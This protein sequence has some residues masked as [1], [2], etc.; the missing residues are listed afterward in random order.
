MAVAFHVEGA[1]GIFGA[2]SPLYFLSEGASLNPYADAVYEL[3]T[4]ASGLSMDEGAVSPSTSTPVGEYLETVR[5]EEP[6]LPVRAPGRA[7]PG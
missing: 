7:G 2:G 1:S 4:D 6:L 3:E 5:K